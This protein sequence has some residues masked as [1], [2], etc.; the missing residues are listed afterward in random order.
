MIPSQIAFSE[1]IILLEARQHELG[2]KCEN[3]CGQIHVKRCDGLFAVESFYNGSR[4]QIRHVRSLREVSIAASRAKVSQTMML[5]VRK[6]SYV[7]RTTGNCMK[8][9]A[10]IY[11]F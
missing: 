5:I 8:A 7:L 1:S 10:Q 4:Q 2:N 9:P 3:I 11:V 6:C